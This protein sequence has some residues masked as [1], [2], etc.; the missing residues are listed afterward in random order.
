[1]GAEVSASG[2]FFTDKVSWNLGYTWLDHQDVSTGK[3][4]KYRPR[5]QFISGV[6]FHPGIFDFSVDYRYLSRYDQIDENFKNIIQ[7]GD[8]RGETHVVDVHVG[9]SLYE[10]GIPASITFHINNLFQ[11]NYIDLIGSIAPIRNF[12]LEV[13]STF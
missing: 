7:N 11:Y 8:I 1:M 4:L 2:Q 5:N 13:E 3:F 12:V 6:G 10:K 9:T